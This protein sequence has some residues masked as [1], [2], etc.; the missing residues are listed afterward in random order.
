MINPKETKL[1]VVIARILSQYQITLLFP[2]RKKIEKVM[3]EVVEQQESHKNA[4]THS[5]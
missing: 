5:L 4:S 2:F 1:I 3:F